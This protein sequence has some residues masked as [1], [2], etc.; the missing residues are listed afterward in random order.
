MSRPLA[1]DQGPDR[2]LALG[3]LEAAQ[4]RSGGRVRSGMGVAAAGA[5]AGADQH[6]R[7]ALVVEQVWVHAPEAGAWNSRS[8]LLG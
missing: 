8:S 7:G 2:G 4:D 3:E 6:E 5:V 1:L